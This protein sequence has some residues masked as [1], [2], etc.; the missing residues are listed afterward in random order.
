MRTTLLILLA[1]L[2]LTVFLAPGPASAF[3]RATATIVDE[4]TGE[5][6]EGAIALAQWMKYSY[7]RNPLEGGTHYLT[8]AKETTS[9]KKGKIKISGYWSLIPFTGTPHLTVY[10]PGYALWNSDKDIIPVKDP[11]SKGFNRFTRVVRLVKFEKAAEEW[12]RIAYSEFE[13]KYPRKSQSAFL[14]NC[15]ETGL[16]TN[17]ITLQKKFRQYEMPFIMGE[18]DQMRRRYEKTKK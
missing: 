18:S 14:G 7:M 2:L 4:E 9:N 17:V 1:T 5:P 12:K 8:K 6:I 16:D 3:L 15:L 10:K 13:K 11:P